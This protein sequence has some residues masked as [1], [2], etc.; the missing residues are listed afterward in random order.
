[1]SSRWRVA[2]RRSMKT[3]PFARRK[4]PFPSSLFTSAFTGSDAV[5]RTRNCIARRTSGGHR[6]AKTGTVASGGS[7]GHDT[8]GRSSGSVGPSSRDRES[9][10]RFIL[11]RAIQPLLLSCGSIQRSQPAVTSSSQRA[12]D[13]L[14][15][16]GGLSKDLH[17]GSKQGFACSFGRAALYN[18]RAS[19]KPCLECA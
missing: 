3:E 1:M 5:C 2:A 15:K 9:L 10:A 8:G 18:R 13:C 7:L 11:N 4:D 14:D 16:R 19:V 17:H 12:R 6:P